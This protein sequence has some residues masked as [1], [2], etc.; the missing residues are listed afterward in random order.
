MRRLTISLAG[1]LPA[2]VALV[3]AVP[4]RA[5]LTGD[6]S[7]ANPDLATQ[8][9]GPYASYDISGS[10]TSYTVTLTYLNG[11]VGG[12]SSILDLNL[13]SA[14][15]AGT[16]GT[17]TIT[18]VSSPCGTLTGTGSNQVDGFGTLSFTTKLSSGFNDP[19]TALSFN[20]TTANS[21]DLSTLLAENDHNAEVA[22]H[23]A[24]GTKTA[25]TGYAANA[26]STNDGGAVSN[27]SCTTSTT[28]PEPT[29]VLLLG[30]A[31]LV[32]GKFLKM[33][34]LV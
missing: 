27:T 33:K 32:A 21:V 15:G 1:V 14:A 29:S 3:A 5:D 20:F 23:F 12:D 19:I 31:L 9:A 34:L 13:S 10:G 28:V 17:V 11:F 8:G 7:V 18:C 30:T 26:G 2:L 6:I 24:L 16:L 4:A 22:G 25:C